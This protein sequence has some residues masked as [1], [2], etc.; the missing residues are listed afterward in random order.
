M[1][2]AIIIEDELES[3]YALANLIE[4][5]CDNIK[6]D[7][8]FGTVNEAIVYLNS[9]SVNLVFL[10]IELPGDNGFALLDHI[11]KPN[12][13][14]IFTTA[15]NH[16][17]FKAF[18]YSAWGYLLKPYGCIELQDAVAKVQRQE[19]LVKIETEYRQVIN[20][21]RSWDRNKIAITHQNGFDLVDFDDILWLEA[22]VNYTIIHLKSGSKFSSSKTLKL[23]ENYL[24]SKQ[25][26]RISRSAIVNLNYVVKFNKK[27]SL[28]VTLVDKTNLVVSES[29]KDEF[30]NIFDK[31]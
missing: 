24:D 20:S 6:L 16:Y 31:I 19:D 8:I 2:K 26:I 22:E 1:L 4:T 27:S 3:Q 12:F 9:N 5:C 7:A 10:D 14:V 13:K 28:T 17:A 18:K 15:Y 25:F 23:F 30:I 21:Y 11:T 29:R